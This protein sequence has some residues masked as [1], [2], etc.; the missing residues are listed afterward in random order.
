MVK[1]E[2]EYRNLKEKP[3]LLDDI[4]TNIG[5]PVSNDGVLDWTKR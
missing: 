1:Y 5:F 3:S 4:L 2:H